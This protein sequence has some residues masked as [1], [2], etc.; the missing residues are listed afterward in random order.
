[1]D[2]LISSKDINIEYLKSFLT[3]AWDMKYVMGKTCKR[4]RGK[5]VGLVFFEPSTRTMASFQAAA[6]NMGGS[7]ININDVYSSTKKG[8]SLEDTIRTMCCYCDAVV[9]RHPL[10]GSSARAAAV[11]T[12]PIINGGDGAGEHPT[13]ALLD[14]FTI[15]E[16]LSRYDRNISDGITVVFVGDLKH[17]RTIHSLIDL[18]CLYPGVKFVYVCPVGLE[19]PD[20]IVN[21]VRGRGFDQVFG[22]TLSEAIVDADVLYVTRIQ[23]ERFENISDYESV[24]GSYVVDAR[25]MNLAKEKMMVMHPLPR[26][27][28]IAVEVDSD[29][30]CAYFKQMTNGVFMRMAILDMLI[31]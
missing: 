30:R 31:G 7:V 4:L 22:L 2:H 28:E 9:L 6:Q 5:I 29:P 20:E 14:V 24:V 19:M 8:E 26:T 11:A 1:M 25:L 13:Q 12:K 15:S 17:S 23:R 10:V 3:R 21:V 16:E 18:L 27:G